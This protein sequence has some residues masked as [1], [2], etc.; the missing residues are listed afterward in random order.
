AFESFLDD[1]SNWYIRRSRQRLWSSGLSPDKRATYATLY[2]VLTSL[3]R[4]M[5]PILPFYTEHIFQNLV[6]AVDDDAPESVHLLRFPGVDERLVAE[7]LEREFAVVLTAKNRCLALRNQ[8]RI[9]IRQP[10]STLILRPASDEDRTLLAKP[11]L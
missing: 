1:F 10:I 3:C 5:A 6:R 11:E 2:E 4:L 7:A 9:K 8:A